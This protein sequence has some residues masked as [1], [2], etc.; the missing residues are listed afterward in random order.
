M[1]YNA[2]FYIGRLNRHD[3]KLGGAYPTFPVAYPVV[4]ILISL[5]RMGEL[6][7]IFIKFREIAAN[8]ALLREAIFRTLISA[9]GPSFSAPIPPAPRGPV[10]PR[11]VTRLYSRLAS[12]KGHFGDRRIARDSHKIPE[13]DV[14][15]T[16]V[17]RG[18]IL[19][20]TKDGGPRFSRSFGPPFR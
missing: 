6:S 12:V 2:Y 16:A 10:F 18:P 15:T 4:P 14:R 3:D 9:G 8:V 1:G 20:Q 19:N 11:N 17:W 5:V 13:I 7:A